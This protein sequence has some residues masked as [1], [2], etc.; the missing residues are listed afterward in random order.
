ME[1]FLARKWFP[2]MAV[3]LDVVTIHICAVSHF[4]LCF[5]FGLCCEVVEL[6]FCFFLPCG[7]VPFA[8][9]RRKIKIISLFVR[10]KNCDDVTCG[11]CTH[12]IMGVSTRTNKKGSQFW[13]YKFEYI[14][15]KYWGI[16][17]LRDCY[18]LMTNL[19]NALIDDNSQM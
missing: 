2:S 9:N 19:W 12:E 15:W 8:M 10:K 3:V 5:K 16:I 17:E 7:I 1:I 6:I 18:N 13:K 4:S 11:Q 14:F